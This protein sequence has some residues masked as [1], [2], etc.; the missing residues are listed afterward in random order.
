MDAHS[1]CL[2]QNSTPKLECLLFFVCYFLLTVAPLIPPIHALTMLSLDLKTPPNETSSFN[3]QS[4]DIIY[5][6][7]CI[8]LHG[9]ETFIVYTTS[10]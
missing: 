9:Q 5:A 6:Y 4:V 8:F 10:L 3:S 2:N 7:F 1:C